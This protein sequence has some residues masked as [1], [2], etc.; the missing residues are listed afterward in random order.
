MGQDYIQ[1]QEIVLKRFRSIV[2]LQKMG[3]ENSKFGLQSL[4]AG[5]ATA[6]ANKLGYL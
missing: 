6:A 1:Q 2:R 3:F 4:L 5:C